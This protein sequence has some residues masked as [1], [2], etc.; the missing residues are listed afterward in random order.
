ME[1]SELTRVY[2][3]FFGSFAEALDNLDDDKTELELYRAITHYGLYGK[4]PELSGVANAFWALLKPVLEKSRKYFENGA[5][6]GAPKGNKNNRY[7]NKNYNQSTTEIQADKDKDMDMDNEEKKKKKKSADKPRGKADAFSIPTDDILKEP[8]EEWLAYKKEKGQP[9]KPQGARAA[10]ER[11][12][13]LSGNDPKT[14][15]EIVEQS[16]GNNWAGL[17]ALKDE[18]RYTTPKS[19]MASYTEADNNKIFTQF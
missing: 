18:P 6:G 14:A 12:R 10:L 11:L 15:Q 1:K 9:Y 13:N 2:F 7:H 8:F 17:F 19:P 5:K 4:E 3:P 16:M